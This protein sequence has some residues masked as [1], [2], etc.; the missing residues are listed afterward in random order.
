MNFSKFKALWE[1]EFLCSFISKSMGECN[2]I[3]QFIYIM[4]G[5]N[6]IDFEINLTISQE[7]VAVSRFIFLNYFL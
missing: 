6:Q 3:P 7:K 2:T 1:S 4:N 5:L